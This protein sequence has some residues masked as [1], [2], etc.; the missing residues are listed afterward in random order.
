MKNAIDVG[1]HASKFTRNF[2]HTTPDLLTTIKK[3]FT[4]LVVDGDWVHVQGDF[5][6][7]NNVIANYIGN[8]YTDDILVYRFVDIKQELVFLRKNMYFIN[9]LSSPAPGDKRLNAIC[10]IAGKAG[11][12]RIMSSDDHK[13]RLV[14]VDKV[15]R[16]LEGKLEDF[17]LSPRVT[18]YDFVIGFKDN[19]VTILQPDTTGFN[20]ARRIKILSNAWKLLKRELRKW[21]K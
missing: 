13:T 17:R 9:I 12:S 15:M 6:Q 7:T 11:D 5:K 8:E 3:K 4:E 18:G 16:V 2:E 19:K 20:I 10:Y 21:R 14:Y 1:S